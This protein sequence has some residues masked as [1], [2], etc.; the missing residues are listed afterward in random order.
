M[1]YCRMSIRWKLELLIVLASSLL[2]AST[3]LL[4]PNAHD[5]DNIVQEV[6]MDLYPNV[7]GHAVFLWV[8]TPSQILLARVDTATHF[9]WAQCEPCS[10]CSPQKRPLFDTRTSTTLRDL[11]CTN[12]SSSRQ[13]SSSCHFNLKYADQSRSSGRLVT[14]TLV[15]LHS[16]KTTILERFIMG[17]ANS[18]EGP[19]SPL[20]SAVLGLG[21]GPLSLHSQL[22]AQAFSMC[23]SAHE[24]S[25]LTFYATSP[26]R[27][28]YDNNS[29]IVPLIHKDSYPHF[30]FV[31][32][33]GIG[34]DGFMLDI[35][36]SVWGY[37]LNYDAGVIVDTGS[38]LT[39]L[40]SEAYNVFGLEIRRKM[41]NFSHTISGLEGLDFC[42]QEQPSN[43][44]PE[45]DLYFENGSTEGENII[46]LKLRDQQ[47]LL[48]PKNG[49]VC[50]AFTQ[51][52]DPALTVLGNTILLGTLLTYDMLNDL[53]I[54]TPK[55][56]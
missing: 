49:I 48:R 9:T 23:L 41:E 12:I 19:S 11:T 55:K 10:T 8:G 40:P 5:G 7:D 39:R 13:D 42:Y 1:S 53:A 17:C 50:L 52:I 25:L 34:V 46:T 15:L 18:H 56:C 2:A 28:H 44:Y 33:V 26:T 37:G 31:Q 45:V 16:N 29:V 47:I 20:F 14:D 38:H 51:G 36:S 54:F 32:F 21:R 35:P 27:E 43:V 24:P 22:H 3:S 6:T 30:Y 4:I